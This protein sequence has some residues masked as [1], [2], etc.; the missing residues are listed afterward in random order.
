MHGQGTLT[1]G[2]GGGKYV[3]EWK[4]GKQW[5]GA[6][7]DRNGNVYYTYS[8]GVGVEAGEVVRGETS[9][10]SER[11]AAERPSSGSQSTT[12]ES[13]AVVTESP[14]SESQSTTMGTITSSIWYEGGTYTG[15][16]KNGKPHGQGTL[17]S[18]G[19]GGYASGKYVGE[20]KDGRK[21]GQGTFSSKEGGGYLG[22]KYV[23]EWKDGRKHGQGSCT[24]SDGN[25]YVGE[26]KDGRKHGQGTGTDA[27]GDKYVGEWKD[28]EKHGQGTETTP[29]GE[30]YV[31]EW[32]RFVLWEGEK[33]DKDCK[34]TF[35]FSEG[36]AVYVE[37]K[38][39]LSGY[40][41]MMYDMIDMAGKDRDCPPPEIVRA[42]L[43][44]LMKEDAC[45]RCDL[46]GVVLTRE[47][48][49][50]VNL[51][52]A[53]MTDS[54]LRI[55]NLNEANLKDATLEKSILFGSSLEGANLLG[56]NFSYVIFFG[57]SLKNANLEGANL[58]GASANGTDF[59]GATLRNAKMTGFREG[60]DL[61]FCK[62]IMPD[63]TE[64]NTDCK[65]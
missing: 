1:Y 64:R 65:E 36:D 48:L 54:R 18:T 41:K 8:E 6:D 25:K 12:I 43:K 33:Y 39:S 61:T 56:A 40:P 49:M 37:K 10:E 31:G 46:G 21:H 51:Q 28:G 3:G 5:K 35:I 57:T 30:K 22:E 42:S 60:T 13:A 16:L 63:G 44:Q 47:K 45:E 34:V 20:W 32:K 59:T 58:T 52:G 11:E 24:W 15:E 2:V 4:D 55:V 62:T 26:W 38:N 27:D 17:N 14:P 9:T 53:N 50:S 23:G 19:E 7:Y 29:D